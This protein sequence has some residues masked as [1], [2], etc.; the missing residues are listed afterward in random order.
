MRDVL[1]VF[2]QWVGRA[3]AT[4]CAG[5]G[6]RRGRARGAV[7]GARARP[8][9]A[10]N[11]TP[12]WRAALCLPPR[13]PHDCRLPSLGLNSYLLDVARHTTPSRSTLSS[14]N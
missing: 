8:P 11:T 6:R 7:R 10:S 13:R 1:F 3:D 5:V 12:A 4:A 14:I 9:S 2:A